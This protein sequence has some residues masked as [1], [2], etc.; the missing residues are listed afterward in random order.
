V[1]PAESSLGESPSAAP[2]A[3]IHPK[4][5]RTL[6]LGWSF[7]AAALLVP[8]LPVFPEF[9][10]T[11]LIYIGIAALVALGLVLVTGIGGMTSFGQAAFV[12]IAAYTTAVLTTRGLWSPWLALPACVVLT[13]VSA[14][15]IGA[16]TVRL[17]SHYMPL[18]TLC[19]GISIYITLG[20]T[21]WL[22]GHDGVRDIPGLALAGHA[23]TSTRAF[24]AVVWL[25]MVLCTV[26]SLNLLDS[27][28]GRAIRAL[29]QGAVSSQSFGV[30]IAATRLIVFTFAAV[31]A[32]VSGW[33]YAVFQ[34]SV[35]AGA[36]GPQAS[37]N[38][39]LMAVAGGGASVFGGFIGAALVTLLR[40][41]LQ[42]VLGAAGNFEGLAFGI[43]LVLMLQVAREGL[44]PHVARWLPARR[45][46]PVE[47]LPRPVAATVAAPPGPLLSVRGVRKSFGGLVAVNDVSFDVQPGEIVALIGPN[48][49]GK[50]TLFNL[51][52]GL[53]RPTAGE[54]LFRGQPLV[55]RNPR[56]IARAGLGRTFQHVK[57][58]QD[59]SVLDNVA[60]GAHLH[61]RAGVLRALT[62]LDRAEERRLLGIATGQLAAVGMQAQAERQAGQLSLGQMRIAEVA[63][64]LC[65]GP[66]LLLL[67]EPAAGLRY[68]EKQ[69]LAQL[70]SEVRAQ[71]VSV[72]IVEHDV[73]FVMNLVD[74]VVVMDFGTRIAEGLPREIQS[75]P[76]VIEAYLGSGE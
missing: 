64:A 20:N 73:E 60:L 6:A 28:V 72:L 23:L 1:K 74:R 17:S 67:D 48:G 13:G 33:L 3:P 5:N 41:E 69:A 45:L 22:G 61:G 35:S 34:H 52:T 54:V 44:W 51:V 70:L 75:N 40:N 16:A 42:D 31:L 56:D 14:A 27:R 50:T 9:W 30:N 7:A 11:L 25:A 38:Y 15:L 21:Q 10:V 43:L 19:W 4:F 36:F 2:T 59:M 71:G 8:M 76:A 29:R 12:G 63:R 46:R 18:G 26:A 32:A 39:L 49:A 62:G 47:K 65:L 37:I 24:Y 57:L 55:G 68:L 53:L 66:S 58:V